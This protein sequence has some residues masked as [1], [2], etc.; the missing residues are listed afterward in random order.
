M[1]ETVIIEKIGDIPDNATELPCAK[2]KTT[3]A[4]CGFCNE[5]L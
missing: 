2:L 1:A 3:L 5:Y 4:A